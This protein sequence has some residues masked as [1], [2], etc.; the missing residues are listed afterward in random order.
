MQGSRKLE[1]AEEMLVARIAAWVEEP[2]GE[3]EGA[4]DLDPDAPQ[5]RRDFVC[6]TSIWHEMLRNGEGRMPSKAESTM[7]G[8]ALS[9]A[10]KGK[11]WTKGR[12][13]TPHYGQVQG[14]RRNETW[15]A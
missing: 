12:E 14:Y 6:V 7:V 9:I 10:M 13:R 11:P 15:R 4:D 3:A 8:Q 5:V 1:T 2:M